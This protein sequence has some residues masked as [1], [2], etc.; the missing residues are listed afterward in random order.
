[1]GGYIWT[2]KDK[3]GDKDKSKNNKLMYFDID[4]DNPLEKYK[5]IWNNIQNV[6]NM[7]FND[8]TVYDDRYIH[9]KINLK[10]IVYWLLWFA[11]IKSWHL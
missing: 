2:F 7:K 3:G 4:D 6:Q 11:N 9:T 1:M 5:T 10:I 8:L